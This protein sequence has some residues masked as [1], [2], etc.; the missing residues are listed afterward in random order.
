MAAVMAVRRSLLPASALGLLAALA[1]VPLPPGWAP[2]DVAASDGD[3]VSQLL[4]A[5][6]FVDAETAAVADDVGAGLAPLRA[7]LVTVEVTVAPTAPRMP[8]AADQPAQTFSALLAIGDR[9]LVGLL[10]RDGVPLVELTLG[11][12]DAL[13]PS[14]ERLL[15]CVPPQRPAGPVDERLSL[16]A[17]TA[18]SVLDG[19]FD[20]E[21]FAAVHFCDARTV[22][23]VADLLAE[24]TDILQI[25]VVGSR[26]LSHP[27]VGQ[28]ILYRTGRGWEEVATDRTD[29]VLRSAEPADLL[30]GVAALVAGAL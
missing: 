23:V 4:R 21:E 12:A 22:A 28:L 8:A 6:G 3:D 29:V 7:P 2:P 18:L 30:P 24:T 9:D 17:F 20:A 11:A 27:P 14:I 1:D 16:A 13:R 26:E 5:A 19:R 10:R 15:A 25:L